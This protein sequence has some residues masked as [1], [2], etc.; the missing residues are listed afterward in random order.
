MIA[1]KQLIYKGELSMAQ[2][3][4]DLRHHLPYYGHSKAQ[5]VCCTQG[6]KYDLGIRV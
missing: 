5:E 6:R 4:D 2:K 3:L 1:T